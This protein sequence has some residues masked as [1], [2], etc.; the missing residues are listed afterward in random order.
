MDTLFDI[1]FSSLIYQFF[2]PLVRVLS[3]IMIAP[4]TGEHS[5]PAKVK[6]GLSLLIVFLLPL[7]PV[8][9]A[10]TIFSFT[11]VWIILQQ[12]IIGTVMGFTMQLAFMAIRFAGELIGVQMGLSIATF[13]DPAGGPSTPVLARFLNILAVLLFLSLDGHLWLLFGLSESFHLIPIRSGLLYPNGYLKLIE[14]SGLL[15]RNGLLL[16]LPLITL[17]L[18]I[19]MSMGLLNRLTPQLSIFVVGF[20]I[21][22]LLG[23]TTLSLLIPII[24]PYSEYIFMTFFERLTEILQAF[25]T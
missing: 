22:L 12:V 7:P 21:T 6:I 11:G 2:F 1:D 17:L 5:V 20:P 19:N 4:I 24:M 15:F 16:A 3:L 8:D 10:I 25:A 18:V 23:L 13:F 14:T 9:N